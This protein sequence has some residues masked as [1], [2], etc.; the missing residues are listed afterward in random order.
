MA[1][2]QAVFKDLS[3]DG[4]RCGLCKRKLAA[5]SAALAEM[6]FQGGG[7][8]EA[9]PEC[10]LLPDAAYSS[11][12]QASTAERYAERLLREQDFS[13]VSCAAFLRELQLA[14]EMEPQCA[15]P[16]KRKKRNLGTER[17]YGGMVVAEHRQVPQC[18]SQEAVRGAGCER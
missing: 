15:R 2:S 17:R 1:A 3:G 14:W 11:T 18:F 9:C 5:H 8:G 7:T 16:D 6:P 12:S 10:G 4:S 13:A